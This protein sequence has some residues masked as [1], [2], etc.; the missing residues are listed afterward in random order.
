MR[1]IIKK[2]KNIYYEYHFNPQ[3]KRNSMINKQSQYIFQPCKIKIT[4][5]FSNLPIDIIVV[6]VC[7]FNKHSHAIVIPNRLRNDR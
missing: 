1:T 5:T 6:L 7:A 3:K 2:S 4:S